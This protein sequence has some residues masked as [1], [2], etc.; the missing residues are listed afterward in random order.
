MFTRV[1]FSFTLTQQE[2]LMGW[3]PSGVTRTRIR[4]TEVNFSE[5]LFKGKEA[6]LAQV[7]RG[8]L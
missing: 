5:F 7:I 2:E 6:N 4:V 8:L 3:H 1:T